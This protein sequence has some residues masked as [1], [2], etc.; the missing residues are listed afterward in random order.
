MEMR[1]EISVVVIALN[2]GEIIGRCLDSVKELATE[3]IVC[4]DDRTTDCT[5]EEAEKRG[6]KAIPYHWEDSFSKARNNA[7]AQAKYKWVMWMDADDVLPEGMAKFVIA[8]IHMAEQQGKDIITCPYVV[9]FNPDGSPAGFRN[10]KVRISRARTLI[11]NYSIHE[12]PIFR[13]DSEMIVETFWVYHKPKSLDTDPGRNL[14][15]IKAALNDPECDRKRLAFYHAREL[16][17]TGKFAEAIPA[18]AEYV[19]DPGWDGEAY[20]AWIDMA[21]CHIFLG[22][23][24]AAKRPCMEAILY[25][26]EICEGY[27]KMGQIAYHLQK[28]Q[29]L[30]DWMMMAITH[31]APSVLFF[32]DSIRWRTHDYIA[33]ALWNLKRYEEGIAH[34]SMALGYM[35]EDPRLKDNFKRFFTQL[36][37]DK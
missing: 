37:G 8:A 30:K 36:R 16:M 24:E 25:R 12:L 29:D 26:P 21:D 1:P 33:V 28:W 34:A 20:R 6:A 2:E 17:H 27:Y 32:D 23:Y 35:P 4:L 31:T 22:Q 19:K 14:R 13:L 15:M 10:L 9:D 5:K 18:F 7:Y 11:W 3:I